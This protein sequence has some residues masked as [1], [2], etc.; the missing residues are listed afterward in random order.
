MSGKS[1]IQKKIQFL[2]YISIMKTTTIVIMFYYTFFF[3]FIAL[4]LS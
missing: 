3:C 4:F 1:I 2:I